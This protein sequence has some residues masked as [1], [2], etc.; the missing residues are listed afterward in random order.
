[1][2]ISS[3]VLNCSISKRSYLGKHS[4]PINLLSIQ[5]LIPEFFTAI[6]QGSTTPSHKLNSP[7][8]HPMV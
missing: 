3:M 2:K 6:T 8:I 1:M 7:L 4:F 5:T